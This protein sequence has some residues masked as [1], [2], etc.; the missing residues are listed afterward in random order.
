VI[1]SPIPSSK[2]VATGPRI[3]TTLRPPTTLRPI[4]VVPTVK[5]GDRSVGVIWPSFSAAG[6]NDP[7]VPSQL[8]R[9]QKLG[10]NRVVFTV[11]WYQKGDRDWW[12][13]PNESTPTDDALRTAIRAARQRN[14]Q[15]VLKPHIDLPGDRWRGEISPAEPDKWFARYTEFISLYAD[16]S[17]QEGVHTVIV[18]TEL[19][20][21][22]ND[23]RWRAVVSRV[24][25]RYGG[26]LTYAANWDEWSRVVFWDLLDEIGIDA[27]YPLADRGGTTN[28][29]ALSEAWAKPLNNLRSLAVRVAKPI[30]F[31]E[32]GYTRH[33]GTTHE[34]FNFRS[35]TPAAPD[36]QRAAFEALFAVWAPQ[37]FWAGA[38]IWAADP[39][40]ET[41][42][43]LGYNPFGHPAQDI[44]A[45]GAALVK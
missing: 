16:L 4:A 35:T 27:Y 10:I 21:T 13:G 44:I 12:F 19:A 17:A 22:S 43:P 33:G 3:T 34:P 38:D 7:T 8:D 45:S 5:P 31:T 40:G 24:R 11:T 42:D 2:P 29:A 41:A 26:R 25:S 6:Y 15:V 28:V 32:V 39:P 18:G 23:Q 9:F 30:R 14:M 1:F 36:E 37:Q 20:R